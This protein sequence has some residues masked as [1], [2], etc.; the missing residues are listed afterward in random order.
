M[1]NRGE[2]GSRLASLTEI[3]ITHEGKY[4]ECRPQGPRDGIQPAPPPRNPPDP[5]NVPRRREEGNGHLGA[6]GRPPRG[7]GVAHRAPCPGRD[8]PA[9]L[10]PSCSV[11]RARAAHGSGG[12]GSGGVGSPTPPGPCPHRGVTVGTGGG[13]VRAARGG[14]LPGA[15]ARP[16]GRGRHPSYL[17]PRR[18]PSPPSPLSFK[19]IAALPRKG[20]PVTGFGCTI[21]RSTARSVSHPMPSTECQLGGVRFRRC[22]PRGHEEL[23]TG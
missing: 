19:K 20:L 7:A 13:G 22:P 15:A 1:G 14:A 16:R 12:S 10:L 2:F 5:G 6:A 4:A 8:G 11:P 17:R 3:G 21:V 23:G 18:P 9:P